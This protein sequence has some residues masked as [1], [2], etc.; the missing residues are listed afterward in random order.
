MDSYQTFSL[1]SER[2]DIRAEELPDGM[3]RLIHFPPFCW[4]ENWVLG[5]LRKCPRIRVWVNPK[6]KSRNFLPLIETKWTG[7][8][9]FTFVWIQVRQVDGITM[10]QQLKPFRRHMPTPRGHPSMRTTLQWEENSQRVG[11]ALIQFNHTTAYLS[12]HQSSH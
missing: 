4:L 5:K 3:C 9:L 2:A 6:L 1:N 10:L 7:K 11:S 8:G 12:N